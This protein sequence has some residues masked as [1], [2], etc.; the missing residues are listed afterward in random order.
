MRILLSSLVVVFAVQTPLAV[1]ATT[2]DP[3][4]SHP[5]HSRQ[6]PDYHAEFAELREKKEQE[7]MAKGIQQITKQ[8]IQNMFDLSWTNDTIAAATKLPLETIAALRLELAT[9]EKK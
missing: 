9:G 3:I 8:F 5:P 7:G 2:E 1:N 6:F 4:S